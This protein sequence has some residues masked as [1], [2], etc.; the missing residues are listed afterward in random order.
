[1]PTFTPYQPGDR[2]FLDEM[3]RL[4]MLETYP[5]VK[6]VGRLELKDRLEAIM[7]RYFD[8]PGEI[9]I[10]REQDTPIGM[11]WWLSEIHPVT[12]VPGL[13]LVALGV[14]PEY[15]RKGVAKALMRIAVD[16]KVPLRLF[17]N[18]HNQGAFRLYESLGFGPKIVEM[19]KSPQ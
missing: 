2:P 10:A 17:V 4:V 14:L 8:I 9:W 3:M 6:D 5:E 1:M 12:E 7:V 16:R 15:R 19:A 18:P 11:L 13:L